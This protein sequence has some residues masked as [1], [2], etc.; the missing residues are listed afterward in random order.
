MTGLVFDEIFLKHGSY[1]HPE[2][3]MRLQVIRD[4]LRKTDLWDRLLH[5]PVRPATMEE[6]QKVHAPKYIKSI[7]T[8]SNEGGG[9]ADTDTVLSAKSYEAAIMAAGGCIE[10]GEAVMAGTVRNAF[11]AVRPPGHHALANSTMGFCVF[12]NVAIL[13]KHLQ[14][15]LDIINILIID[16]DI[17]HGNGTQ[18]AFYDDPTVFFFSMHGFPMFPGTG[19]KGESGT[20]L[21]REH[22]VNIPVYPGTDRETYLRVFKH[23]LEI[24]GE[25]FIPGF[26]LISAGFDTYKDDPV[27]G[28]GLEIDDFAQLTDWV[29]QFADEHC[30]GRIVSVLEG[31]YHLE[32]LPLSVEA[33]LRVLSGQ[34]QSL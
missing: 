25:R 7:E 18:E 8:I 12:N 27:G 16:W 33:H 23:S 22:N 2:S 4:H 34:T 26:I 28:L 29:V 15:H 3:P 1:D 6:L 20:G 24:I 14:Y 13:A 30:D 5:L 11:C 31:G 32:A 9:Q 21:G 19:A 10:A 17:H